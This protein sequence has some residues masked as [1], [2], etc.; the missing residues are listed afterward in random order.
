MAVN[1][2]GSGLSYNFR[3]TAKTVGKHRPDV[4]LAYSHSDKRNL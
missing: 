2:P 4:I 1:P 3:P